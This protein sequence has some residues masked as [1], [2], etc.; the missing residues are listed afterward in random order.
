MIKPTLSTSQD[1]VDIELRDLQ[2]E[3][4]PRISARDLTTMVRNQP[5][6]VFVCD[7][8]SP[9]EYRRAHLASA[10]TINIPFTS[11]MLGNTRLETLQVAD[12]DQRMAGRIVVVVSCVPENDILVSG[13]CR[14]NKGKNIYV[15]PCWLVLQVPSGLWRRPGVH[16]AQRI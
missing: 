11:V 6:S 2:D 16:F 13:W 1:I 4:S 15:I 3:I 8:R 9:S 7:L 10:S 12:L 5:D 14:T